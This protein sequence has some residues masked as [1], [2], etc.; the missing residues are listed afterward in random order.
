MTKTI[1][2]LISSTS[3]KAA[4]RLTR[5][6]FIGRLGIGAAALGTGGLV[7]IPQ[8]TAAGASPS[9]CAGESVTCNILYGKNGCAGGLCNDGS[10]CVGPGNCD[11]VEC[12]ATRWHDCCIRSSQCGCH[13]VSGY[14]SCCNGCVWGVNC[15]ARTGWVVRCRYHT[16]C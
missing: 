14:P 3:V 8:A 6:S 2:R 1:D 7:G 13:Y 9:F 5:R 10:W 15:S 4:N 12:G 11:Y 16:C